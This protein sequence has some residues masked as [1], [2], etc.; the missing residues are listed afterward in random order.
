MSDTPLTD[1]R[2]STGWSGDAAAVDVAF[3]QRLERQRNR[4][5]VALKTSICP[6]PRGGVDGSVH[7]C[8]KRGQCECDNA[9][10]L[11]F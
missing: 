10:A 3:C 7:D 11:K 9:A 8:V 5:R 6:S 2:A 4:L 1:K